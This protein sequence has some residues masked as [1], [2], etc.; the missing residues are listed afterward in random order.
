MKFAQSINEVSG[1]PE[2]VVTM[3]AA[4]RL[5]AKERNGVL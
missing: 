3:V 2:G 4:E 5:I 1:I